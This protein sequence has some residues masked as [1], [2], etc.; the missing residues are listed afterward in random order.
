MKIT[1]AD[2]VHLKH[3][4]DDDINPLVSIDGDL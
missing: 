2:S 1:N 3:V 4:E